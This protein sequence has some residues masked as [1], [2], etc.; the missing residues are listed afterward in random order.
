M[1]SSRVNEER[2]AGSAMLDWVVREDTSEEMP[3][4]Q[5]PE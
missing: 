1:E 3:F 2:V 5:N 4:E